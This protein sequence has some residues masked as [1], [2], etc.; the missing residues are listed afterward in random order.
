MDTDFQLH[1]NEGRRKYLTPEERKT[2]EEA[3]KNLDRDSMMFCHTL[4][5]TGGRISEVLE[6]TPVRFDLVRKEIIIRSLKKRSEKAKYR[7]V[8]VP[9]R[10]LRDLKL[11]YDLE[12]LQKDKELKNQRIWSWSRENGWKKV[13]K[14]MKLAGIDLEAPHACPKGLRHGF[15]VHLAMAGVPESQI[16]QLLGHSSREVTAI[17]TNVLG[18]EKRELISKIW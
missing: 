10:L 18:L 15:G 3:A 17:Y 12:R 6:L 13:K 4:L 9:D 5:H 1:D 11:V 14:A 16:Q 7:V 2:F 8:P